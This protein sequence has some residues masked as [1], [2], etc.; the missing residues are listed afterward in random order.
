[1][2]EKD[3]DNTDRTVDSDPAKRRWKHSGPW[4][5]G[6]TEGDFKTYIKR[7]IRDK[8]G[9]FNDYLVS[10]IRN[11]AEADRR[12]ELEAKGQ[13]PGDSAVVSEED[14]ADRMKALRDGLDRGSA[15]EPLDSELSNL[16]RE[17]LDLPPLHAGTSEKGKY[18]K[19]F[20]SAGEQTQ[21]EP[22]TT[23]ASAGLSYLRSNAYLQ[24][25]PVLGPQSSHIPVQARVLQPKNVGGGGSNTARLGVAGVAV[26]YS[27]T[28]RGKETGIDFLDP[29][30]EGGT[31][32]WVVPKRAH[33]DSRG[34]IQLDVD[35]ADSVTEQVHQGKAFQKTQTP[36][37]PMSRLG[38]PGRFDDVFDVQKISSPRPARPAPN[39]ASQVSGQDALSF[40]S[41]L[42]QQSGQQPR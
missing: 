6:M 30:A 26:N 10:H 16:I 3:I 39:P 25:H 13:E 2:F 21:V 38:G 35:R 24:N 27:R 15:E 4:I 31:K 34:R 23:H 42:A 12:R 9:E 1:M 36:A 8:K 17:Y 29:E 22:P 20:Q 37:V 18:D 5:A 40:I 28:E 32:I 14:I 11:R 33:I 41:Q 7:E 19:F